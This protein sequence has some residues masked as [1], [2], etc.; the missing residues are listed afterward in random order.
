MVKV[1]RVGEMLAFEGFDE[2]NTTVTF[3]CG[4]DCSV[5]S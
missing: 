3:D 4:S 5:T 2:L 1:S